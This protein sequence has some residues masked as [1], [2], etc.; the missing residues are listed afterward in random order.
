MQY[1][2][3]NALHVPWAAQPSA[4]PAFKFNASAPP[5]PHPFLRSLP[6]SY[7][8][9]YFVLDSFA[10]GARQ[11]RDYCATLHHQLPEEVRAAVGLPPGSG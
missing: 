3:N 1:S 11:L 8:A 4:S 10:E 7:Q 2:V 5:P 9:Q 6:C